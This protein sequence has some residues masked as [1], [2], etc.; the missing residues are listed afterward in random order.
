MLYLLWLVS[1]VF[2]L[3]QLG[4]SWVLFMIAVLVYIIVINL[5]AFIAMGIDKDRAKKKK[6]RIPEKRL[7]FYAII[8]GGVGGCLGMGFFRHK[9][10]HWYF[11]VFF[12]LIA[13]AQLVGYYYLIKY[14]Y[15]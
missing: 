5:V 13:F 6:W 1:I 15:Y 2:L 14:L 10:K 8:G 12:P 9:T 3:A 11:Q 4:A 7:F